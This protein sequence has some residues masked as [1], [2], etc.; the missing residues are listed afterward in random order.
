[1][2]VFQNDEP[3]VFNSFICTVRWRGLEDGLENAALMEQVE[4]QIREMA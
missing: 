1:M 3:T 4:F 2:T